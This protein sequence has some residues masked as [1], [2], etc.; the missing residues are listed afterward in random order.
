MGGKRTEN[1]RKKKN[2]ICPKVW[3]G[4][5]DFIKIS[6]PTL[7]GTNPS[8]CLYWWNKA[9]CFNLSFG[10]IDQDIQGAAKEQNELKIFWRK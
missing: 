10:V 8:G 2:Q 6:L 1:K 4:K 3:S 9:S 7:P 5:P